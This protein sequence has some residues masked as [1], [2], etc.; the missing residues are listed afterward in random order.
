MRLELVAIR[1][2]SMVDVQRHNA[3]SIR[4]YV[5]SEYIQ[6]AKKSQRCPVDVGVGDVHDKLNMNQRLPQVSAAI[7]A[8]LFYSRRRQPAHDRRP[9]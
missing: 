8:D 9:S 7:G 5:N 3:R 4:E 1:R 2:D 6:S